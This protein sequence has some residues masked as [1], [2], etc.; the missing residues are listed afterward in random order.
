MNASPTSSVSSGSPGVSTAVPGPRDDF[1]SWPAAIALTTLLGLLSFAYY[2]LDDAVRGYKPALLG[3]L[4]EELTGYW[5]MLVLLPVGIRI[6]RRY[7]PALHW[8]MLAHVAGLL[9]ISAAGT[10]WN[11]ATRSLLFPLLG[12]GAYD[13]GRMPLRYLMELPK[14]A[15]IYVIVLA[16]VTLIDRYQAARERQLNVA[17]LESSLARAQ[18]QNL[19][20][21][22]QPHFLF[23]ALNTISSVM[24]D[25]VERADHMISSLSELLR[26]SLHASQAQQ[27]P[28]AQEL[29]VLDRYLELM[30]AR[31]GDRLAVDVAVDDGLD[32]AL[33][34]AMVLQP[35]VEN[36]MQHGAP[37]PPAVAR[38]DI[39]ARRDGGQLVLEVRDNGPG[40]RGDPL[41]RGV[42]LTN[43][44]DRLRALYGD[45]QSLAFE[46]APN[47]GLIVR[48]T[49]PHRAAAAP[50]REDAWSLSAS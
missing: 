33:V 25:D 17:R 10:T 31:F 21:Q 19:H 41:G 23:N 13:Y 46:N 38:V 37:P 12:L 40:L 26:A 20:T 22:L 47:G 9:A 48:M 1:W 8:R 7:P 24:Y 3:T 15:I 4:V 43:T 2:S 34:P 30:R 16:F 27:I 6:V 39:R 28:L 49:M 45:E 36:A 32:S 29:A 35:I 11:W 14:A 5:G 18:L 44:A 50:A 42:G